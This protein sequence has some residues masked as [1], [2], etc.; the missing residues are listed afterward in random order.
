MENCNLHDKTIKDLKEDLE[1]LRTSMHEIRNYLNV[2]NGKLETLVNIPI[3]NG[4]GLT[5][6]VSNVELQQKL[7]SDISELKNKLSDI[8]SVDRMLSMI[9]ENKEDIATIFDE[10]RASKSDNKTVR[11]NHK[12]QTIQY[13]L[14]FLSML[15][16]I[17]LFF[18]IKR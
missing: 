13:I 16:N 9:E 7:Y 5:V 1:A 4:G 10:Y 14:L 3:K 15:I 11:I 8:T 2:L 18:H 6:M 17:V 12:M